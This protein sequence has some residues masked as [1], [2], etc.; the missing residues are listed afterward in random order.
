MFEIFVVRLLLIPV[1]PVLTVGQ[2]SAPVTSI[3]HLWLAVAQMFSARRT[4]PAVSTQ[5]KSAKAAWQS[6][7]ELRSFFCP[8]QLSCLTQPKMRP[9]P[10]IQKDKRRTKEQRRTR[11]ESRAPLNWGGAAFASWRHRLSLL[12][13]Q[14]TDPHTL[15]HFSL[16]QREF[17]A[18]CL[19]VLRRCNQMEEEFWFG[20]LGVSLDLCWLVLLSVMDLLVL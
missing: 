12:L 6:A 16:D 14:R 1:L 13:L 18:G 11:K 8:L 15:T 17:W 4:L 7:A 19:F 5:N 10:W 3:P 2:M 20:T 9:F